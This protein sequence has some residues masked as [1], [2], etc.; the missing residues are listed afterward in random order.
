MMRT[1]LL[2]LMLLAATVLPAWSKTVGLWRDAPMYMSDGLVQALKEAGW[3]TVTLGRADLADGGKLDKLD[4]VFLPGGWNAYT[5]AGFRARRNW[6]R[7][8]PCA[9]LS[10]PEK[11]HSPPT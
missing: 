5:Y 6:P 9:S 11:K 10:S 8:T 7:R 1:A 2:S 4:V 3:E